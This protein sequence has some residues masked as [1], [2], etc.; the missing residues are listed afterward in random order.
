METLE[1]SAIEWGLASRALP[2]QP[3]SGDLQVVKAFPGGVLIAALDG[4]GH[5]GEAATAAMIAGAILE[6]HAADPVIAIVQRCH[7]ALRATRGVTMSVASFNVSQRLVTW[8]GV[9]NVLGV[10]L[11]QSVAPVAAEE[12]LLLRAGVV[13]LHLPS[14]EA[15]IVPVSEGDT[16]IFATDGIQSNFARG[17][18]RSHPPRKAAEIILARHGKTT[19]DALVLVAQFLAGRA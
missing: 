16:L 15:D 4:I 1:S 5:G 3:T 13:G 11:R 7:E 18:A 8:L 19:D 6:T 10:L 9:G 17:L 2:G 14:L 12:S